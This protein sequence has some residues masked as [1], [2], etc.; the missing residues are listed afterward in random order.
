MAEVTDDGIEYPDPEFQPGS[1]QHTLQGFWQSSG[2]LSQVVGMGHHRHWT[3]KVNFTA[4]GK[5]WMI[6]TETGR[7]KSKK[8][9]LMHWSADSGTSGRWERAGCKL[10]LY[11][12]K[13]PAEK[14]KTKDGGQTFDSTQVCVVF[15]SIQRRRWFGPTGQH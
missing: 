10:I 5:Y 4:D 9:Q 11:W 8:K 14:L 6:K 13:W 2:E 12:F 15:S 7:T 1:W 3:G